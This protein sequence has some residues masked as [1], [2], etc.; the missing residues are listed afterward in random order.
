MIE[1]TYILIIV[2]LSAIA[3]N[4]QPERKNIDNIKKQNTKEVLI[5]KTEE[6]HTSELK[7]DSLLPLH[8]PRRD[9]FYSLNNINDTIDFICNC[10]KDI[11]NNRILI[12]LRKKF[13]ARSELLK[14]NY[15]GKG[16]LIESGFPIQITYITLSIKDSIVEFSEICRMSQEPQF[17]GKYKIIKP[18]KKYNI[19]LTKNKYNIAQDIW[20]EFEFV[21]PFDFG[22]FPNDTLIH[23]FFHC[24]NSKIKDLN[25]R[26]PYPKK[27]VSIINENL[28]FRSKS[29]YR[30]DEIFDAANPWECDCRMN[31]TKDT[32]IITNMHGDGS[33]GDMLTIKID[34]NLKPHFIYETWTDCCS[35]FYLRYEFSKYKMVLNKNPF[36][37]GYSN[38]VGTYWIASEPSPKLFGERLIKKGI[39]RCK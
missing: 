21:L 36:K 30:D 9:Y 25:K 32:L 19:T 33:S 37:N 38:L 26:Q 10:E 34:K 12:Q 1:K 28:T 18:L 7:F 13:P 11:K 4:N 22:I 17:N 31:S 23:G 39:F 24:N 15:K 6:K 27:Q 3:C 5:K 29:N 8:N 20:G 2:L 14:K 16:M 35:D